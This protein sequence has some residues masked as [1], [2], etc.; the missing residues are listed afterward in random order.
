LKWEGEGKLTHPAILQKNLQGFQ[1]RLS[2]G[3]QRRGEN[4]HL[5]NLILNVKNMWRQG[6]LVFY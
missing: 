2:H 3:M 1:Q 4:I 5:Q 6:I